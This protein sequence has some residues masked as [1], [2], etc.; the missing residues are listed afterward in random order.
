MEQ[1]KEVLRH[2]AVVCKY[3]YVSLVV[4]KLLINVTAK[5]E[6]EIGHIWNFVSLRRYEMLKQ[7]P[8]VWHFGWKLKQLKMGENID[9]LTAFRIYCIQQGLVWEYLVNKKDIPDG[10]KKA[11][12]WEL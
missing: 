11:T 1:V 7:T 3:I 8:I 12:I 4:N 10:S 6:I 2:Y 9:K 5:Y